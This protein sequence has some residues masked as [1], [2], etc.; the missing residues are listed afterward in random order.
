MRIALAGSGMLAHGIMRALLNSRHEIVALIQNG[1]SMKR[2]PPF[3]K[4][5]AY[6]LFPLETNV[7]G[8][9]VRRGIPIILIDK[10]TEAEL[11][12]LRA[13]EPDLLLVSGFGVILKRP[14]LALPR[15]GCVNVHTSL[16]PKHR[17]PNPFSAVVMA[18][19]RESGVTFHIID[20]GIDTGP[21]VDQYAFEIT[22]KDSALSVH[23]KGSRVAAANV[24][25]VIDEIAA[26]GLQGTPQ[27]ES[28]ATYDQKLT[29]EVCRID[30]T[31]S[32]EELHRLFRGCRPFIIPWFEWR[33][34]RVFVSI[35]KPDETPVDAAPGTVL[36][37]QP[38]LR[39]AT[40]QGSVIVVSA[41]TK[42]FP[43]IWPSRKNRP[44]VG[45]RLG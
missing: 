39:I 14:I 35:I 22:P 3:L 19:E 12:P 38:R 43:W 26:N 6:R 41:Y 7:V 8:M 15:I 45:E 29:R 31:R 30:W 13:L 16:L 34:G 27:D 10:M 4:K 28:L 36:E 11:A 1:R 9:A 32:A 42:R 23:H 40:G 18:G 2:V 20:E 33:K 17:G 37:N 44:D 21:I 25:G 5:A 24:V